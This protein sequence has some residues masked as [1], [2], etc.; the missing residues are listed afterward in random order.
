[1]LSSFLVLEISFKQSKSTKHLTS[2]LSHY[3]HNGNHI[4]SKAI[5]KVY[6]ALLHHL[7]DPVVLHI[8]MLSIHIVL[9]FAC[10]CDSGLV[11]GKESE[12]VSKEAK[13]FQE[14]ALKLETL[15]YAMHHYNI[16]TLHS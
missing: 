11:V 14:E 5:Y 13:N 12:R 7:V 2:F 4:I 3:K 6:S 10:K 9:I 15:L 1:M 8:D 16:L